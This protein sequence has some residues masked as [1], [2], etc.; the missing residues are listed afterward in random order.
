MVGGFGLGPLF[1]C[2]GLFGSWTTGPGREPFGGMVRS[3]QGFF[4]LTAPDRRDADETARG[5]D[6]HEWGE[7]LVSLGV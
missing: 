1:F 2:G 7:T 3:T 4:S 5:F 6:G